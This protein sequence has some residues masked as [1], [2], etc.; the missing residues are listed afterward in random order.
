MKALNLFLKSL[1]FIFILFP[2]SVFAETVYVLE[3]SGKGID[4]AT[5]ST[6]TDLAKEAV[7]QNSGYSV[8]E[9]KANADL[10]VK[11]SLHKLGSS[12]VVTGVKKSKQ[13]KGLYRTKLKASSIEDMDTVVERVV[14]SLLE[15]ESTKKNANVDD[16]TEDEVT[17]G[18]RRFEALKQW[19]FSIGPAWG[20]D[21]NTKKTSMAYNVGYNWIVDPQY[22]ISL[23]FD[24]FIPEGNNDALFANL[25]M[26]VGY[27]FNKN[28]NAP[29]I[30]GEFGYAWVASSDPSEGGLFPSLSSDDKANGFSLGAGIGYKF[31]RTSTT[32]IGVVLRH[33]ISLVETSTTKSKPQ[34]TTLALR[35][36]WD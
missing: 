28:K 33:N 5:L 7:V 22:D 13:D 9:D 8:V 27:Y 10:K 23:G 4:E 16:V 21:L 29:F 26:G 24:W 20:K 19:S 34:L 25:A 18:T 31:F 2:V 17:R 12:Y 1:I 11:I 36:Y 3:T 15:E 35:I 6:M 14:R 32:N 30:I